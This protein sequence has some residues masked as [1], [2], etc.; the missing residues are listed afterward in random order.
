MV[1]VQLRHSVPPV[2]YVWRIVGVVFVWLLW[3]TGRALA[4]QASLGSIPSDHQP[5]NFPLFHF[6]VSLKI[7]LFHEAS[8]KQ[9]YNRLIQLKEDMH[10]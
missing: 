8:S 6:K 10:T 7:A 2:Q 4:P 5:F 3:L 1:C 9:N